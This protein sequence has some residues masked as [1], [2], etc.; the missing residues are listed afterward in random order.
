MFDCR[1]YHLYFFLF[2]IFYT[3]IQPEYQFFCH[4]NELW[5]E[6]VRSY[7]RSNQNRT[8]HQDQVIW[9]QWCC[10]VQ[11]CVRYTPFYRT[12]VSAS[13]S[14][15]FDPLSRSLFH[16]TAWTSLLAPARSHLPCLHNSRNLAQLQYQFLIVLL[17]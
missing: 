15:E 6:C 12:S 11:F 16:P 2:L 10:R 8:G 14:T 1:F 17:L 7:P 5:W 4:N 13:L 9:R 3:W